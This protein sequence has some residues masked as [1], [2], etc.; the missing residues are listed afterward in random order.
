MSSLISDGT[1]IGDT[2]KNF[3]YGL[4]KKVVHHL[5]RRYKG[6]QAN[7]DNTRSGILKTGERSEKA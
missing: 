7:K 1:A 4:R 5:P 2:I 3:G 6:E